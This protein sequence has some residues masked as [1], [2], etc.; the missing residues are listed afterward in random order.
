MTDDRLLTPSEIAAWAA[1]VWLAWTPQEKRLVREA[2]A[3]LDWL[4]R[5]A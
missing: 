2:L 3:D 4:R 1:R 5:A